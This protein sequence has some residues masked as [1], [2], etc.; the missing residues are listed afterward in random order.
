M[1][2]LL[3][4]FRRGDWAE[5]KRIF[6]FGNLANITLTGRIESNFSEKREKNEFLFRTN[7]GFF[8]LE[9]EF[10]YQWSM[11]LYDQ[12]FAVISDLL[13]F[14]IYWFKFDQSF[15]VSHKNLY[16]SEF[17][18]TGDSAKECQG[19]HSIRERLVSGLYFNRKR[20]QTNVEY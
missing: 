15:G 4:Y 17:G 20:L 11:N 14:A 3:D 8:M 9:Y 13:G 19:C 1:E 2:K 16:N 12:P 5:A 10:N 18:Y 6:I 7:P